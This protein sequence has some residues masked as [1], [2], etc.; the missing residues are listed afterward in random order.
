MLREVSRDSCVKML[1]SGVTLIDL[2]TY[3]SNNEIKFI[4]LMIEK[5]IELRRVWHEV[6]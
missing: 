3:I 6:G 1:W 5:W 2:L 4:L